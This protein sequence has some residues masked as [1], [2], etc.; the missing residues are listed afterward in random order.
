[1][2]CVATRV[3]RKAESVLAFTLH[4][5][6]HDVCFAVFVC[7]AFPFTVD[8]GLAP[9]AASVS[10]ESGCGPEVFSILLGNFVFCYRFARSSFLG[11]MKR[12]CIF[13]PQTSRYDIN[14][15]LLH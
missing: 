12:I 6:H 14:G 8:G 2:T 10:E 7:R 1:M 9:V 13:Y 3:W 4:L 11:E 5:L 15:Q